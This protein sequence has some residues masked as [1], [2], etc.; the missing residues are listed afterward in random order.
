MNTFDKLIA[1]ERLPINPENSHQH[2]HVHK[3]L[4]R[5]L[6]AQNQQSSEKLCVT[7]MWVG[8]TLLA[9]TTEIPHFGIPRLMSAAAGVNPLFGED[10]SLAC[11]MAG[12]GFGAS[13]SHLLPHTLSRKSSTNNLTSLC[14][15]EGKEGNAIPGKA[16]KIFTLKKLD[17]SV[18]QLEA[19]H[20]A[21]MVY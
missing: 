3:W 12:L 4:Q 2:L 5:A 14:P 11:R 13:V 19:L 7:G 6:K 18:Y 8:N 20:S 17:G 1:A 16:L 15:S 9:I 10:T 21:A